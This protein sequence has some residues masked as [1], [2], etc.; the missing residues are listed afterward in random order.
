MIYIK[1]RNIIPRLNIFDD[2][3]PKYTDEI[4]NSKYDNDKLEHLIELDNHQSSFDG[5]MILVIVFLISQILKTLFITL[6]Q[7]IKNMP[8]FTSYVS[9]QATSS[10]NYR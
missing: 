3:V 10:H 2:N 4:G 6:C 5:V 7:V 1:I 9:N 8:F